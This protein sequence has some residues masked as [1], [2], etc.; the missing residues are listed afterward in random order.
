MNQEDP[1]LFIVNTEPDAKLTNGEAWHSDV[2]CG[3]IPPM[4]SILYVTRCPEN[5]G[6]DT[7]F[8]NMH[9]AFAELSSE[10][11]QL[12]IGKS[13]TMTARLICETTAFVCAMVKPTQ[14]HRT[15]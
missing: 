4:A 1:E 14:R 11:Q 8:A 6:G 3:E 13:P 10:L 9:A 15:P 5:G 7:M 2:S 12:L